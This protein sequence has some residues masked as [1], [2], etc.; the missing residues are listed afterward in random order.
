M[1]LMK[2]EATRIVRA[3]RAGQQRRMMTMNERGT[4]SAAS[5]GDSDL[6]VER[7]LCE[8]A[9]FEQVLLLVAG[10]GRGAR[11]ASDV[12]DAA[13]AA[14]PVGRLL[15]RSERRVEARHDVRPGAHV[16]VFFLQPAD[17]SL[18]ELLELRDHQ[19]VRE[20]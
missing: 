6:H 14:G 13:L 3:N 9:H 1:D 8:L 19:V 18:R 4:R 16:L 11:R 15:E 17:L 10:G 5:I 12:L 7:L 2:P 20:R